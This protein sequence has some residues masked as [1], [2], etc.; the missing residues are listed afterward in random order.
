MSKILLTM[1]LVLASIGGTEVLS[2]AEISP[3]T[4]NLSVDAVEAAPDQTPAVQEPVAGE[5]FFM[6]RNP[7]K[8]KCIEKCYSDEKVKCEKDNKSKN[9]PGTKE[10]WDESTKCQEKYWKCLNQFCP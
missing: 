9:Q 1:L 5:I 7:D 6:A 3:A 8:E 4:V 2:L 10:N